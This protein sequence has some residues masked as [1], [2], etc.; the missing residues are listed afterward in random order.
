MS[1]EAHHRKSGPGRKHQHCALHFDVAT[2]RYWKHP[3][4]Q[5]LKSAQGMINWQGLQVMSY[6]EKD[7]LT[8]VRLALQVGED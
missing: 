7:R 1:V 3:P 6:Q 4:R 2:R 8:R 5:R